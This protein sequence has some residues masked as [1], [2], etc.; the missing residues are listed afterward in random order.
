MWNHIFSNVWE[1]KRLIILIQPKV[2]QKKHGRAE[3]HFEKR[4]FCDN[5]VPK[6]DLELWYL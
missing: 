4:V 6:T 5:L 2:T 1:T 3:K